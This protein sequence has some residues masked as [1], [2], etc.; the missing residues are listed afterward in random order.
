MTDKPIEPPDDP[1][2]TPTWWSPPGTEKRFCPGCEHWFSSRGPA[3]CPECLEGK[4]RPHIRAADAAR[5]RRS[6][7]V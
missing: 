1:N 7:S 3:L 2:V 6:R 4:N 5:Q